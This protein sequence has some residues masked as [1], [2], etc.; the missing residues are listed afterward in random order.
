ML[1][2]EFWVMIYAAS[3][4]KGK[5]IRDMDQPDHT[6]DI[7]QA[8]NGSREVRSRSIWRPAETDLL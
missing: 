3:W 2:L 7:P 1:D 4:G 5:S 8:T 6:L